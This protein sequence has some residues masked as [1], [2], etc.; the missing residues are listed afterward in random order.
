MPTSISSPLYSACIA[1]N[2]WINQQNDDTGLTYTYLAGAVTSTVHAARHTSYT[3][4]RIT[5]RRTFKEQEAV[6]MYLLFSLLSG[7]YSL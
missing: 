3:D 7:N 6:Y 2:E 4:V 5:R 1:L